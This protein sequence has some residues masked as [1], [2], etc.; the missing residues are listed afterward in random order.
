MRIMSNKTKAEIFEAVN[1]INWHNDHG[2]EN[3]TEDQ[4]YRLNDLLDKWVH[5]GVYLKEEEH[6]PIPKGKSLN[7][8]E[9]FENW[10]SSLT[11]LTTK[12][13]ESSSTRS[14]Q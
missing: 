8:T 1:L 6:N 12:S 9:I 3:M 7:K 11:P 5:L 13:T 14:K 4:I 10:C 2:V